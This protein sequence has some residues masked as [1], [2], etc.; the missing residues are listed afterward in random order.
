MPFSF[1]QVDALQEREEQIEMKKNLKE[2][3]RI[4]EQMY[5]D[6]RNELLRKQEEE[7]QIKK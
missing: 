4:R 1:T 2:I 7:E 6:Q 5:T 3:D